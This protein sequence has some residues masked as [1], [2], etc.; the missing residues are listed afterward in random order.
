MKFLNYQQVRSIF[1]K[2]YN[3]G[4]CVLVTELGNVSN[5][6]WT[7]P[8]NIVKPPYYETLNKPSSTT[9]TIEIKNDEQI[10]LMRESCRLGKTF[11]RTFATQ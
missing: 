1:S 5:S 11:T 10:R 6:R 8:D 4:T 2:K 9:G 3:L 7:V